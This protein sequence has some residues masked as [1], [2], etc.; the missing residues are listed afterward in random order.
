MFLVSNKDLLVKIPIIFLIFA[1]AV[2]P[3]IYLPYLQNTQGQLLIRDNHGNI[4]SNSIKDTI[5]KP[6]A[7]TLILITL[8]M[9]V[10]LY[11]MIK[12]EEVRLSWKSFY[13]PLA[14]F[15]GFIVVST[16]LS[17]YKVVAIYGKNMRCEGLLVVASYL[18]LFLVAM[19][20][21]KDK[22]YLKQIVKYLIISGVIISI[23]GLLQYFGFDFI[24]RDPYREHWNHRAF[25]TLGNPDFAGSYVSMLLP[26]SFILYY[27]VERNN[28]KLFLLGTITTIFY[29]FMLATGTRSTYLAM[30]CLIPIGYYFIKN[31]LANK[32]KR[33]VLIMLVF[34][35]ITLF[36]NYINQGYLLNRFISIFLDGKALLWGNEQEVNSAGSY[37]MLIYKTSVPLLFKHPWFGQGLDTFHKVYPQEIYQNFTG[38][39][40]I[41]LDKAHCEYLQLGITVGIPALIAYL[42]FLFRVIKFNLKSVSVKDKYH[43][44]LLI[45]VLG[46]LIQATFNISVVS[47]APVFW[48]LMGLSISCCNFL[49][50]N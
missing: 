14:L 25:S 10:V 32:K 12:K 15:F 21:V 31:D 29:T 26:L 28:K 33:F 6:K 20:L 47:V 5:Y 3:L 38:N 8:C 27:Y 40:N 2:V 49:Q 30:L 45:A 11:F 48:V 23:Y 9:L 19:N 41:I 4:I 34:I 16:I 50:D 1:V 39:K 44:A 7:D 35:I 42:W 43:L 18:V 46:Y 22:V 17:P 36:F 24:P 37:R 13:T